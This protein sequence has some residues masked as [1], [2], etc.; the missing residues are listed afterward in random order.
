[1]EERAGLAEAD[2]GAAAFGCQ[3]LEL[4]EREVLLAPAE[5]QHHGFG[6]GA[7][8]GNGALGAGGD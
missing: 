7:Q 4:I 5:E 3:R 2:H 8:P 6:E 1:V